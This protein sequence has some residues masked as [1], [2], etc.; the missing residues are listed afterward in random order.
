[1]SP[2]EIQEALANGTL[3]RLSPAQANALGH[4]VRVNHRGALTNARDPH[5]D[6]YSRVVVELTK[7]AFGEGADLPIG[8]PGTLR[9]GEE[10]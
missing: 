4:E 10:P 7:A 6:L 9:T 1:M 8:Q 2:L 3:S 5:H